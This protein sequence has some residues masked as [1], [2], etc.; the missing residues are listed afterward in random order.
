MRAQYPL[1]HG[2]LLSTRDPREGRGYVAILAKFEPS[3]IFP[4]C[5][6]L[7]TREGKG[8]EAILARF[9]PFVIFSSMLYNEKPEKAGLM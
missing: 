8:Y 7:G 3:L 4:P 6:A 2:P 5:W 9:G 1:P